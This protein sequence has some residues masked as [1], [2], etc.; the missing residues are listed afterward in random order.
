MKMFAS[1]QNNNNKS[2]D[3]GEG[4]GMSPANSSTA[5]SCRATKAAQGAV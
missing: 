2:T 4:G 3:N 1:I 5:L